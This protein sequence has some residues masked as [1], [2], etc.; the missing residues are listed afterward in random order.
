MKPSQFISRADIDDAYDKLSQQLEATTLMFEYEQRANMPL[1]EK[2]E[3]LAAELTHNS[4]N[5]EREIE[6]WK[7]GSKAQADEID[8]LRRNYEQYES[9]LKQIA[10]PLNEAPQ[11]KHPAAHLRKIARKALADRS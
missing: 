6:A 9:A 5:F 3:E 11:H 7:R 10:D 2:V 8:F 4:I 1:R